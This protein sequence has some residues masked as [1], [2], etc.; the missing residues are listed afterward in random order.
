MKTLTDITDS[1]LQTMSD[2][3]SQKISHYEASAAAKTSNALCN[4]IELN[5]KLGGDV[6]KYVASRFSQE[7]AS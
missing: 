2:L 5:H 4:A 1:L 7:K 3:M 6:T